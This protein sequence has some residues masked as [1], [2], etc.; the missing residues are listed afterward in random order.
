MEG[1]TD[2]T[3]LQLGTLPVTSACYTAHP[4]TDRRIYALLAACLLT[5]C[6]AW[7]QTPST[8]SARQN[9]K[10][11][12][13]E[14][15]MTIDVTTASRREAPV[16]STAAAVSV[17]T[18][19]DIRRSG[20]TTIVDALLLAD[21][22]N[23]SRVN[24]T[25]WAVTARGFNQTTANKL[26]VM[27]DGRTEYSPLFSGVFWNTLDYVLEDIERIE[28][29]RGPGAVLWGANAVNG[30]VNIITRSAHETT[31]G[32]A[33]LS[34]GTE[35][36]GIAEFRYG[37][38]LAGGPAWRVYGKFADRDAHRL[39]SGASSG[40]SV[41]RGQTGFRLDAGTA[42]ATS[43]MLKGDLFHSANE[44]PGIPSGELTNGALQ[45][46]WAQ[47][48]TP[49][50]RFAVQSYF[51]REY[52]RVPLQ[53]THRLHTIDVDAQHVWAPPRHELVWGAGFRLNDDSTEGGTLRFNPTERSYRVGNV[54]AQDEFEVMPARVFVTVGTKWEHNTFS[55][56]EFQPNVRARVHLP[57]RQMAWSA[58]SRAVRRPTRFEDDL[59]I[60]NPAGGT[61]LQGSDDF[62][63]E[64]LVALEGGYRVQP[65]RS[66]S[67]DV[68]AFRHRIDR[69]RS[70]EAPISPGLPN[71]LGNTLI[72]HVHGLETAINVQPFSAWRTHLTYTWLDS[73]VERAPGSRDLSGGVTEAN[74]PRHQFGVR[75]SV[76]LP[77]N[78]QFDA[79]LR[80]VSELPNLIVPGFSEL[81]LRV[82]WLP[83]P[84]I[85]VWFSGQDLLHDQHPEFGAPVAT[86]VEFER[87]VRAGVAVRF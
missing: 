43:W 53:L 55:G 1:C 78:M 38:T 17:V 30:V 51:R 20:V 82:G 80:S 8:I 48:V 62:E 86:R 10:A 70:I 50:S 19:D 66:V 52:R 23:V 56:G 79:M 41:R 67:V 59:I 24:N 69:L 39:A 14:E 5:P 47:S 81:S 64:S 15:L 16:E 58:L 54:F 7:T 29:I 49:T 46:R 3:A 71:T 65:V 63:P 45:A 42:A 13:I 61:F 68:A 60:P 11:L 84:A 37:D 33:S 72:G 25:D 75:S 40:D 74:D 83:S 36:N 44:F 87:S 76:D 73:S 31:G 18:H 26:L 21:G 22:V 27:I 9:L 28:V 57:H 34:A 35:S 6:W 4:M 77:R 2:G 12:S 32:Y 85:E